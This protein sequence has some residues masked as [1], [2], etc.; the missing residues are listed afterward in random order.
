M[1]IMALSNIAGIGGGGIAI[2]MAMEFFGLSTKKAIANA[3][4]AIL[5]STLARFFFNL[6]QKHPAKKNV[7]IID[8]NMAAVMMPTNM[9]GSLLGAYIYVSFPALYL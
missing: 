6:N 2:P 8:Y 9:A 5:F 4:F 7:C 3:S 1:F